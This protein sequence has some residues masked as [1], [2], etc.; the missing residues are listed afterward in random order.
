MFY[1]HLVPAASNSLCSFVCWG[2]EPEAVIISG[3]KGERLMDKEIL[4]TL[5]VPVSS[6][7]L[8][9]FFLGIL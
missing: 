3:F 2:I 4:A 6:S 7:L 8:Q 5:E 9:N 1:A